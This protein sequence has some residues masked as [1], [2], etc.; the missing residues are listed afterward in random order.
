VFIPV[1][2]PADVS[3]ALQGPAGEQLVRVTVRV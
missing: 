2:G 1:V 3:L